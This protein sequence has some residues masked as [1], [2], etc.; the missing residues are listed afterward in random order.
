MNK[1]IS[2]CSAYQSFCHRDDLC[3]LPTKSPPLSGA[4]SNSSNFTC[5]HLHFLKD[6]VQATNTII[7]TSDCDM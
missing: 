7:L 2:C 1:V 3:G 5:G 4:E 6:F